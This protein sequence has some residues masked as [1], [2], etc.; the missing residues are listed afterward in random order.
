MSFSSALLPS[1][2][3]KLVHIATMNFIQMPWVATTV[4]IA[5]HLTVVLWEIESISSVQPHSHVNSQVL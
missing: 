4:N 1:L 2:Q 3:L 5:K